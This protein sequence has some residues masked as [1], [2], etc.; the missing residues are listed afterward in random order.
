VPAKLD[1]KMA[2]DI[3]KRALEFNYKKLVLVAEDIDFIPLCRHLISL[4]D[5]ITEASFRI[6]IA[7]FT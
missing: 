7:G 4:N 2:I 6:F 3:M 1:I 5:K